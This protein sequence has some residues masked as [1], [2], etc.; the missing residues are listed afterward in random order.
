MYDKEYTINI[1]CI[2]CRAITF[3]AD[4]PLFVARAILAAK[5]RPRAGSQTLLEMDRANPTVQARSR[6]QK[7]KKTGRKCH[8]KSRAALEHGYQQGQD[9]AEH[10][11]RHD[12]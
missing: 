6:A 10:E 9:D 1:S 3:K 7:E 8:L 5:N 11:D 4:F 12:Q 2:L